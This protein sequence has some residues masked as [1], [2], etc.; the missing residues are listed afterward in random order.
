MTMTAEDPSSPRAVLLVED[1]LALCG[2]LASALR[3]AGY[4][5]QTA[6]DRAQAVQRFALPQTPALVL[7]DLGLPP[8]ASTLTEGLAVLDHLLRQAPSTKIIV[9]TGPS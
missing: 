3:D 2:Y 6:H 1:D 5:V 7:L 8:H 4:G 9:L